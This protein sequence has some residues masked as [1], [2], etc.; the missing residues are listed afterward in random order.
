NDFGAVA[1][2]I[3]Q[4]GPEQFDHL[5]GP[6]G[7]LPAEGVTTVVGP[8]TGLGVAQLL[9]AQDGYHVMETEGGHIDFAPLDA[10][11]DKILAYLRRSFRRVSVERIACGTGLVNLYYAIAAIEG[12]AV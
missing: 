8:G 9:K 5:C 3:G 6:G 12:Q 11:E 1:H 4:F 7:P 2:A 10:L